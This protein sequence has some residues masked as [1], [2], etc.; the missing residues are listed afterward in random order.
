MGGAGR[1]ASR[2]PAAKGHPELEQPQV[3]RP[4]ETTKP[5]IC[6]ARR[7]S[8]P[9]LAAPFLTTS[10]GRGRSATAHA[11]RRAAAPSHCTKREGGEK[12]FKRMRSSRR[13]KKARSALAVRGGQSACAYAFPSQGRGNIVRLRSGRVGGLDARSLPA[14]SSDSQES[15]L[16]SPALSGQKMDSAH[17]MTSFQYFVFSFVS[18][19][20]PSL[21]AELLISS[22]LFSSTHQYGA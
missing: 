5:P 10:L 17:L 6:Q 3:P 19:A 12:R 20:D 22:W 13:R 21:N 11:L 1:Q 9:A 2:L 8:M 14:L 18:S 15:C 16:R 4:R 7:P